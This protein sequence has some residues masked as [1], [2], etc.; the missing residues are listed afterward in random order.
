MHTRPGKRR[1]PLDKATGAAEGGGHQSNYVAQ[2]AF[3]LRDLIFMCRV[4]PPHRGHCAAAHLFL[5]C[6]HPSAEIAARRRDGLERGGVLRNR[7]E[8]PPVRSFR[9]IVNTV[10]AA[11]SQGFQ[12]RSRPSK[13]KTDSWSRYGCRPAQFSQ[14][15]LTHLDFFNRHRALSSR[16]SKYDQGAL[17]LWAPRRRSK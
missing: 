7:R 4:R 6:C 10:N 9:Q 5:S 2:T 12:T 15:A 17:R 3:A 1:G 13:A 11:A 8:L 14:F 16:P